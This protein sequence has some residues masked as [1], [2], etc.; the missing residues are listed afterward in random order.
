M[1]REATKEYMR[2]WRK[3]NAE[4]MKKYFKRYCYENRE[5]A[6]ER[7]RLWAINNPE[8]KK[9]YAKKWKLK[10]RKKIE[11][12]KTNFNNNHPNYIKNWIKNNVEKAS[13]IFRRYREKNKH[14]IKA[15][16]IANKAHPIKQICSVIGC[17]E[18]GE[19]HH[20]NYDEPLEIIW[21]C[22]KHHKEL[23]NNKL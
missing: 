4:K 11:Q 23:H 17:N 9:E 2:Q 14:R 15:Q 10:N 22:R 16:K 3:N 21:L 8:K 20:S 13:I 5:K 6:R 7:S 19:R 1:N 18:L 12:Y